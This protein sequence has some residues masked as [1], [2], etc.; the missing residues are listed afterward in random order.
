MTT[1]PLTLPEMPARDLATAQQRLAALQKEAREARAKLQPSAAAVGAA[2]KNDPHYKNLRQQVALRNGHD[3]RTLEDIIN[4]IEAQNRS[5]PRNKP[6]I[7]YPTADQL[8]EEGRIRKWPTNYAA[9]E[10]RDTRR[11]C[12]LILGKARRWS[13]SLKYERHGLG[14]ILSGGLGCG[15]SRIAE[16]AA[17]SLTKMHIFEGIRPEITYDPY[18]GTT[19]KNYSFTRRAV[20]LMGYEAIALAADEEFALGRLGVPRIRLVVLDDVGREGERQ[21]VAAASQTAVRQELYFRFINAIYSWNRLEPDKKVSLMLTTN[22][23]IKDKLFGEFFND[24]TADRLR[25][26]CPKGHKQQFPQMDSLRPLLEAQG[27]VL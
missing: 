6:V 17:S 1:S 8:D 22:L 19:S 7:S 3:S 11:T 24:A 14:L 5:D 15:K 13:D 10:D 18:S 27:G 26:M 25:E 20:F 23:P 2:I 12:E 16:A 4:G 21:Y 9:V